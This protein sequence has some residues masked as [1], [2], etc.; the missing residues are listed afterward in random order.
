MRV[1]ADD[2]LKCPKEDNPREYITDDAKGTEVLESAYYIRLIGDGSLVR[3]PP[4][5]PG[6]KG[7]DGKKGGSE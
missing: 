2:G 7:A 5:A 4:V 1:R 6:V 3:I